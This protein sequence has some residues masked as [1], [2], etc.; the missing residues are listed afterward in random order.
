MTLLFLNVIFLVQYIRKT[1][2][3]HVKKSSQLFKEAGGKGNG[4]GLEGE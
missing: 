2:L 1:K 4:G 3:I